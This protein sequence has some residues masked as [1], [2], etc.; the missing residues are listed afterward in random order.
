MKKLT[1]YFLTLL[2]CISA[3]GL[4]AQREIQTQ[5]IPMTDKVN[6]FNTPLH[7]LKPEYKIPYGL[8]TVENVKSTIDRVL[9]FLEVATPAK[10]LN[11]ETKLPITDFSKIDKNAV[12]EQG[13]FRLASYEWGV[14]YSGMLLAAETT[15]D[16]RYK[17][18]VSDRFNFLADVA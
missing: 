15:G 14:T 8:P 9:S 16:V 5:N 2:F 13:K 7:M 12:L 4:Q 18:Y 3:F 11:K 1:S 10:V 17:K 6:D